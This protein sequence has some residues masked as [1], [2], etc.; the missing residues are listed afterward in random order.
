MSELK[1]IDQFFK[2]QLNEWELA[3]SNY[4]RLAGMAVKTIHFGDFPVHVQFNPKR[5]LSS[6]ARVDPQS[7]SERPCFLCGYNRPVEQKNIPYGDGF[8][9]LVNPYPVFPLHLTI[10][11]LEHKP[12]RIVGNFGPML[13]LARDLPDLTLIYNGPSCGASA[14]DHFHFQAIPKGV[15]PV[16][17]DFSAGKAN[18][19]GI[20]ESITVFTWNND[21]RNPISLTGKEPAAIQ[22]IFNLLY[23]LLE[24]SLPSS[25]EPMMNLLAQFDR[26]RWIVHLFPRKQHRPAQ[27]FE[28]GDKQLM[29][30]PASIDL[31]G[32]LIMAREE[33]FN[34]IS[35]PVIKDVFDQVCVDDFF[36]GDIMKKLTEQYGRS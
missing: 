28:R 17:S 13:Q 14:P 12:Q 5:I 30:S 15:L 32:V 29:L 34:K 16:E 4:A 20:Y 33:D 1:G 22:H 24:E 11:T 19:E 7:L 6:S 2:S 23:H 9:I 35:A 25:D 26:N 18:Q 21:V 27:Y 8:L 10:P 36:I 3:G 31:G